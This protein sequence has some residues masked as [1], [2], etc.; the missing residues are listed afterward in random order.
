MRKKYD[1]R[2]E[3]WKEYNIGLNQMTH[4]LVNRE[5]LERCPHL[6]PLNNFVDL[7]CLEAIKSTEIHLRIL[8]CFVRY[9]LLLPFFLPLLEQKTLPLFGT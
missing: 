5:L 3:W 1:E 6:N 8:L 4:D 7:F 9:Y 2:R